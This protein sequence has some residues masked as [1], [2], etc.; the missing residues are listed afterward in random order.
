[1]TKGTVVREKWGKQR[2]WFPRRNGTVVQT[3][4]LDEVLVVWPDG[5]ESWHWRYMLKP[6]RNRV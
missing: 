1:M 5:R 3:T 6:E 2:D 4:D